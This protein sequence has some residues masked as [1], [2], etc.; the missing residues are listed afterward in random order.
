[1]VRIRISGIIF[2]LEG[3]MEFR[4]SIWIAGGTS[5]LIHHIHVGMGSRDL[6]LLHVLM[7]VVKAASNSAPIV[8]CDLWQL[9]HPSSPFV[10]EKL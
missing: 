3:V 6:G 5:R 7:C 10:T 4:C 1:M 9:C 2:K 8:S